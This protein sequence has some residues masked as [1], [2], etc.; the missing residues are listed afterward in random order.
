LQALEL[1]V[2]EMPLV[3]PVEVRRRFRVHAYPHEVV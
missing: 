1:E 2:L 3:L